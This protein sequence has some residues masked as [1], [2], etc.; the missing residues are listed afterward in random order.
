M[1]EIKRNI[2]K[3]FTLCALST[4]FLLSFQLMTVSAKTTGNTYGFLVS[5]ISGGAGNSTDIS[6]GKVQS[7][8]KDNR[9]K[10]YAG[11]KKFKE[12]RYN[13]EKNGISKSE[14]TKRIRDTYL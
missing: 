12:L 13:S 6:I 1:K 14:F 3:C 11:Q 5:G 2:L 7:T 10:N 8:L 9:L 4:V